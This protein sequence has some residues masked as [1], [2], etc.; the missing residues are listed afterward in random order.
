[1]S[2]ATH[3]EWVDFEPTSQ[4]TPFGFQGTELWQPNI[5]IWV[6]SSKAA[7]NSCKLERLLQ[8]TE[9]LFM[10]CFTH[11]NII[12]LSEYLP[13]EI[14]IF[15]SACYQMKCFTGDSFSFFGNRFCQYLTYF[16]YFTWSSYKVFKGIKIFW[17]I[18]SRPFIRYQ[19]NNL[20]LFW[21]WCCF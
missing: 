17:T 11:T 16:F 9:F 8:V 20:D 10:Y 1:M 15:I 21:K 19:C 18:L 6:F 14:V 13:T 2:A 3:T 12:F 4:N 5:Y 7:Y